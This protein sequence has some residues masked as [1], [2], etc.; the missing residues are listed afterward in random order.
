MRVRREDRDRVADLHRAAARRRARNGAD[1]RA[2]RSHCLRVGEARAEGCDLHLAAA[3]EVLQR[4]RLRLVDRLGVHG[5]AGRRCDVGSHLLLA[6]LREVRIAVRL[7]VVRQADARVRLDGRA[8]ARLDRGRRVAVPARAVELVAV[9]RVV[10][11]ELVP[12]LVCHVVDGEEVADRGRKAGAARSL[13]LAPDDAEAGDASAR[14]PEREVADV[15]VRRADDLADDD[16]LPRCRAAEDLGL[17]EAAGGAAGTVRRRGRAV[18]VQV[19]EVVVRNELHPD[20]QVV[21]VDL[22]DAVHQGD[23]GRRHVGRPAEERR[24]AGVGDHREPVGAEL[25][26]GRWIRGRIVVA[27]DLVARVGARRAVRR[28]DDADV[29]LPVRV[30][31]EA[32]VERALSVG[33]GVDGPVGRVLGRVADRDGDRGVLREAAAVQ[34]HRVGGVVVALVHRELGQVGLALDER[35]VC[36]RRVP[37][38][39]ARMNAGV[40]ADEVRIDVPGAV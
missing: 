27:H 39:V 29:E 30:G 17:R 38:V 8:A 25:R 21:L 20:R 23:L 1:C 2:R 31:H 35:A 15:V 5:R 11:G 36:V 12:E 40:T 22:V 7:E 24:V 37:P 9:E 16:A 19:E 14:L 3:A 26:P 33:R 32:R 34:R 4:N 13:V 10:S 6:A 18:V 28:L